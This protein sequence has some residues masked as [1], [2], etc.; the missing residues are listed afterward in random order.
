MRRL[1]AD[2]VFRAARDKTQRELNSRPEVRAAKAAQ[3]RQRRA[4]PEC[5]LKRLA[6]CSVR[7][8][9][10]SMSR[11]ELV[12]YRKLR[13]GGVERMEAIRTVQHER[14]IAERPFA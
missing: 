14:F 4:D 12:L 13:N 9:L 5:E 6:G 10:P 8:P 2:P 3:L 1:N 11:R 7:A